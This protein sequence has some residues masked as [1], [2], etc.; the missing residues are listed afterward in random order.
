MQLVDLIGRARPPQPWAEGDNIPWDEPGFSARMLREHLSQEHDRASRR[1]ATINRHVAW[2][3][4]IVLGGRPSAILDLGCGPG[5]YAGRLARLGH[6]CVGVDFS[7][8]SVAYARAE[9]EQYGLACRYELADLREADL[10]AGFDLAMLIF[11]ELNVFPRDQAAALIRRARDALVPGGTLLLEVHT[12]AAIQAMGARP[13]TWATA[14]SGLF[15]EAPYLLLTEGFWDAATS[16]ATTRYYAVDAASAEVTRHAQSFQAYTDAAYVDLLHAGG[17]VDIT[18]R[19]GLT[20]GQEPDQP[21]VQVL[22]A[23]REPRKELG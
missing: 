12:L 15:G 21:D 10:G 5:L 16:T 7:P 6:R 11:G 1:A 23:R 8:A 22:V 18:I 20:G 13:A 2:I 14:P 9:A 17:F 4:A 3:H 19:P